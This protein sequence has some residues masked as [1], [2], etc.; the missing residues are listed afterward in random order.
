MTLCSALTWRIVCVHRDA[1]F[2]VLV[3][4]STLRLE[5]FLR[6]FEALTENDDL[7]EALGCG[8]KPLYSEFFLSLL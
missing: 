1:C 3:I 6:G 4:S 2:F 5:Y 8:F 7:R